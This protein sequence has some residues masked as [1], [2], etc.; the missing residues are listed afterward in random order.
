MTNKREDP[1]LSDWMSTSV[2]CHNVSA[3]EAAVTSPTEE[4]AVEEAYYDDEWH[5]LVN[6][7]TGPTLGRGVMAGSPGW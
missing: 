3:F 4:V 6:K 5:E 2:G 7:K 1:G